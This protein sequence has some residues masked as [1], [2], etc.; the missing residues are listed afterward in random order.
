MVVQRVADIIGLEVQDV[1]AA[2]KYRKIVQARSLPS[3]NRHRYAR[4]DRRQTGK[5]AEIPR[6]W[7]CPPEEVEKDQDSYVSAFNYL[8]PVTI[9]LIGKELLGLL[10]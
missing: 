6:A 10:I 5:R 7:L 9:F 8:K 2:G 4:N 1:W 3:D